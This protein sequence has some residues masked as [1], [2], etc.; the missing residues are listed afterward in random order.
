MACHLH[1]V[2]MSQG[3]FFGFA[4]SFGVKLLL[5]GRGLPP[6]QSRPLYEGIFRRPVTGHLLD[7]SYR[8]CEL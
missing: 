7:V 3:L 2:M 6:N 4:D 5:H 1:S 8:A